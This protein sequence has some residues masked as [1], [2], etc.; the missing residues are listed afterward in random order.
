MSDQHRQGADNLYWDA[1][2]HEWVTKDEL[3]AR[4]HHYADAAE[5]VPY[6]LCRLWHR[7]RTGV[8]LPAASDYRRHAEWL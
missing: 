8:W 2:C 6:R 1:N 7:V 3:Y 4:C 5:K